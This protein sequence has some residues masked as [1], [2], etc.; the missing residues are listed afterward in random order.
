[1]FVNTIFSGLYYPNPGFQTIVH[2]TKH[3]PGLRRQEIL[4]QLPV[5]QTPLLFTNSFS[6]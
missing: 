2:Q 4:K 1:M 3:N 6:Q 5:F